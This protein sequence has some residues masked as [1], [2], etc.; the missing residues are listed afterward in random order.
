MWLRRWGSDQTNAHRFYHATLDLGFCGKAEKFLVSD[1]NRAEEHVIQPNCV[2]EIQFIEVSRN[3]SGD[4]TFSL[5][6]L[7]LDQVMEFQSHFP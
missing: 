2:S 1:K 7:G 5:H 3:M 6:S 4:C